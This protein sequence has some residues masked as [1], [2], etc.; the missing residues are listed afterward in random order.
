MED[1]RLATRR[2]CATK[3]DFEAELWRLWPSESETSR[4]G[5]TVQLNYIDHWLIYVM[6]SMMVGAIIDFILPVSWPDWARW[7]DFCR[8]PT[9]FALTRWRGN[10]LLLSSVLDCFTSFFFISFL[11]NARIE[12]SHCQER[13][14]LLVDHSRTN[15]GHQISSKLWISFGY[16]IP[17]KKPSKR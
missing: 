10:L 16:L 8:S 2:L 15:S 11:C 14:T 3:R 12:F 4:N 13:S 5:Y 7:I 6:K 9:N 17:T 1:A